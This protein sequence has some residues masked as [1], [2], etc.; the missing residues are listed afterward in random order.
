VVESLERGA[1]A[2]THG[3]S[4]DGQ[5][6]TSPVKKDRERRVYGSSYISAKRSLPGEQNPYGRSTNPDEEV[7]GGE[8]FL[9]RPI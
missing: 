2:V 1:A 9:P 6:A 5:E 3:D 7:A 8:I 4:G